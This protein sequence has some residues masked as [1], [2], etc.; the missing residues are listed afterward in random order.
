MSR[1][2]A[3]D[4]SEDTVFV[5]TNRETSSTFIRVNGA[6][7]PIEPGTDFGSVVTNAA[8]DSGLGKFRVFL[9]G[10]EI[11]PSEKPETVL[12]GSQMELRP[13]DVAG[14]RQ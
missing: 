4:G 9:N 8:R 10:D 12:E 2:E 7:L 1:D 5:E 6:N 3:W 13:Y 11:K 14:A